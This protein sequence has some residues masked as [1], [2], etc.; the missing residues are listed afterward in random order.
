M[1][2]SHTVLLVGRKQEVT[3]NH[4][5][6]QEILHMA[7]LVKK[8]KN[9]LTINGTNDEIYFFYFYSVKK[10]SMLCVKFI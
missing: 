3:L 9:D 4:E 1:K 10:R 6:V 2:T 5:G 8:N 7:L